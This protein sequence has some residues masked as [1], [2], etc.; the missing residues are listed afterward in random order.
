MVAA[1]MSVTVPTM[2]PPGFATVQRVPNHPTVEVLVGP[3]G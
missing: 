2:D 3:T 1:V